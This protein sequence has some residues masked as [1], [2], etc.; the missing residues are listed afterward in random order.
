MRGAKA[1]IR[2]AGR[3]R[4]GIGRPWNVEDGEAEVSNERRKG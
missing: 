1:Q 2:R 3:R 4:A